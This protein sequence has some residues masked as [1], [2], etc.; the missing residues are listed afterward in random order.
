[1]IPALKVEIIVEA[2]SQPKIIAL[3]DKLQINGYSIIK[4]VTGRGT[5]GTCDAEEI[6]DIF[7][8]IYIIVICTQEQSTP[9]LEGMRP[10]IKKYGGIVFTSTVSV[11]KK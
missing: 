6:S 1:M 7:K 10:L 3:L 4:D 11:L 5:H 9:L 2:V 8:N